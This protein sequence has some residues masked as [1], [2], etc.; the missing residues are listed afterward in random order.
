MTEKQE[1][2]RRIEAAVS[3]LEVLMSLY[4]SDEHYGIFLAIRGAKEALWRAKELSQEDEPDP[5]QHPAD[6][7]AEFVD[8]VLRNSVGR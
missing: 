3:D 4:P 5:E 8:F 6:N 7:M 2:T 1:R